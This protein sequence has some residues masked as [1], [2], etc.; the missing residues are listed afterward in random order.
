M[1]RNIEGEKIYSTHTNSCTSS[2]N[3]F[4]K[5]CLNPDAEDKRS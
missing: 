3:I 4:I 2:G 1:L 5:N